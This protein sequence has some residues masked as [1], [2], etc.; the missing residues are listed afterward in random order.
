MFGKRKWYEDN[1]KVV[2]KGCGYSVSEWDVDRDGYCDDCSKVECDEC[3][4]EFYKSD[5]TKGVCDDCED[6][7]FTEWK[8]ERREKERTY[9][10]DRL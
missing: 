4:K 6:R 5:L 9:W 2:C 3:G 7:L 8:N 10:E 1:D